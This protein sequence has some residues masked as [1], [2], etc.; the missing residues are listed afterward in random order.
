VTP[1][2]KR[3]RE[4]SWQPQRTGVSNILLLGGTGFVGRAVCDKLVERSGG[5]GGP[6][7]VPS[8]QPQRAKAIQLLPTIQLHKADVHDEATL[9]R[10][11]AGRDAVINL[12]ATLHGS[13]AELQRVHVELPRK[14]ARACLATGVRRVVHVSALGAA[15]G[16]PSRYLRTKAQGEAVLRDAGLALTV[17]RPSVIFG[18]EDRFLNLFAKLQALFPVMPLACADARFQPVWVNDVAQA[19]VTAL[20]QPDSIGHTF[21]CVGPRVYTLAELVRMAGRWSGHERPVVALPAALGRLQAMLMEWLPGEPLMSRDNIDSM[22]V[23]NVATG[24][25]PALEALGIAPTAIEGVMAPWLSRLGEATRLDVWRR[26]AGR[27]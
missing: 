19:I 14:L 26:G 17:L 15:D 18:A 12:V 8:R 10:L 4:T 20:D 5:S 13:E 23:A 1:D 3:L 2:P 21:E 16:A 11:V 7:T 6:V 24:A 25:A 27:A 22:Q 9:T